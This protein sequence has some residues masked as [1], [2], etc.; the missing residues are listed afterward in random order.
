MLYAALIGSEIIFW[1]LLLG[2]LAVRYGLG[3]HRVSTVILGVIVVNETAL[4]GLAGWDLRRS[5]HASIDHVITAAAFGY[6]VVYA[7]RDLREADKWVQRK[8]RRTGQQQNTPPASRTKRTGQAHARAER[9]GWYRH[10]RMWLVGVTLMMLGVLAGGSLDAGR[11]LF[12]SALVWTIILIIDGMIS[13]SY[14]LWP[15]KPP[16]SGEQR[17][18]SQG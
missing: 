11:T 17:E 2:A 18:R 9:R 4:L 3:W 1:I 13:F 16:Q 12:Y 14:T 8:L 6:I 7:P 10:A 15:K 5:G